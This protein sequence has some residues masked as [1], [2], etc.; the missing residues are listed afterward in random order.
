MLD[1]KHTE[2]FFPSPTQTPTQL[3]LLREWIVVIRRSSQINQ[4]LGHG[5]NV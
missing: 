5:R 1:K 4:P 3:K 2:T